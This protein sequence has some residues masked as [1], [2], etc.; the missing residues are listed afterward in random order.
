VSITTNVV[1]SNPVGWACIGSED[2]NVKITYGIPDIT[3]QSEKLSWAT[4]NKQKNGIQI[5]GSEGV[6]PTIN[7]FN[8][9]Y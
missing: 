2:E 9:F 5:T 4:K 1:D 3:F 6:K 8:I 7:F